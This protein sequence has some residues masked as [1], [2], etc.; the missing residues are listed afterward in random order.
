MVVLCGSE[1]VFGTFKRLIDDDTRNKFFFELTAFFTPGVI[2]SL[3]S[4]LLLLFSIH[5]VKVRYDLCQ[6]ESI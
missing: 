6:N 1:I 5:I 2:Q 4:T 3:A